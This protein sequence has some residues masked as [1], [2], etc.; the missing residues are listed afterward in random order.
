HSNHV[1][2]PRFIGHMTSS[3]PFFVRPFSKLMVALNQNMVKSETAKAFTPFERQALA[4]LHRL[5]FNF[6][7]EFYEQHIQHRES[8]LGMIVSGGT[9]ANLA[10][11]WCARN[12]ILGQRDDFPGVESEGMAAALKFYGYRSA[13]VIGSSLM[14]YSLRKA[15]D[16]LGIGERNIIR[17]D[18]ENN[19]RVKL[20]DLRRA[21]S[22]C[23][24]KRQ[25]I[26]ALIGIAG[27]TDSGAIDPL[28]E[29]AKIA[30]QEGIHFHIDAAWGGPLL[31]SARHRHK[32]NGIELAD[33]VTIDGHK[34]MYLPIGIGMVIL[35]SPN[36]AKAI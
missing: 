3:L 19:H 32:L 17:I 4:R 6:P 35:R 26:L 8:T 36:L 2:S 29:M 30:H 9:Q 28:A 24:A 22:E 1:S 5:I 34:Q 16:L 21:I 7:P 25:L 20:Q 14:H 10:A 31:F 23:R 33:S 27:T 13:V 12:F 18:A 15:G 11:L